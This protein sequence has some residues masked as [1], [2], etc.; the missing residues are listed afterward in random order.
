M[1]IE[2]RTPESEIERYLTARIV[3][4]KKALVY[5]MCA[6]GEQTLNAA[7]STNSYKDR[8]GNLRSSLGYVVSLDGAIVQMSS[9]GRVNKGGKG[10]ASGKDFARRLVKSYPRGLVLIVVAG[11][12]YAAYVSAKGYDVLDSAELLAERL[13]PQMLKKLKLK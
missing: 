4:I 8:T 12:N 5:R 11:M 3:A 7:R 2:N 10:A 9:F 1:P 6:I 13:V